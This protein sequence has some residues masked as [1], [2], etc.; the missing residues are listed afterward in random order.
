MRQK[1][2]GS[3]E[4]VER[5]YAAIREVGKQGELTREVI[6]ELLGLNK[7]D[8]AGVDFLYSRDG[9][10]TA[11]ELAKATGLTSGSTTALIDRLQ[12]AGYAVREADPGDRRRQLVRLSDRAHAGCQ[13]L[14]E[15]IR[16]DLFHFWSKYS[17]QELQLIESFLIE[18]IQFHEK[19]LEHLRSSQ[20][21][22]RKTKEKSSSKARKQP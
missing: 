16:K 3:K 13:A 12:E 14:Y 2:K 10:C 5:L 7:T 8:L 1:E 17:V 20:P 9:V 21:H 11:G 22:F 6:A 19:S 18:G 4:L 15:P